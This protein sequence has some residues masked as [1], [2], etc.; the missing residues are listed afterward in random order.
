MQDLN[1]RD[2]LFYRRGF[3]VTKNSIEITHKKKVAKKFKDLLNDKRIVCLDIP[4]NYERMQPELV[5][6]LENRVPKY[7]RL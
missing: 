6:L 4:D 5:R 3:S 7:V 1:F 2:V